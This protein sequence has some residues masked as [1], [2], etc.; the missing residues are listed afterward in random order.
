M[1]NIVICTIIIDIESKQLADTATF[2][3]GMK[4]KQIL[5][6]AMVMFATMVAADVAAV[7]TQETAEPVEMVQ[8]QPLTESVEEEA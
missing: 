4:M 6:M 1:T 5:V 3:G 2:K 7:N 8:L